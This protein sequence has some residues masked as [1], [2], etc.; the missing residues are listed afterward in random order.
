MDG[1][2]DPV[3]GAAVQRHGVALVAATLVR[4]LIAGGLMAAPVATAQ[5]AVAIVIES[6]TIEPLDIAACQYRW[7]VTV[8]NDGDVPAGRE[9][10]MQ[11]SQGRSRGNWQ[12]AGGIAV[13][14]IAPGGT[15]T[16]TLTFVRAADTNQIRIQL[17][18]EGHV[19]AEKIGPLPEQPPFD[20]RLTNFRRTATTY[21]VDVDNPQAEGVADVTLQV[22]RGSAKSPR[23]WRPGGGQ[24]LECVP[25][26]GHFRR[27][28]ELASDAPLL[29]VQLKRGSTVLRERV[30]DTRLR[31]QM[32]AGEAPAPR[33]PGA[34]STRVPA[35]RAESASRSQQRPRTHDVRAKIRKMQLRDGKN[36]VDRTQGGLRLYVRARGGQPLEYTIS[37]RGGR[38]LRSTR[39]SKNGVCLRCA[40]DDAG[41]RHCWQ[42]VCPSTGARQIRRH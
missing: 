18:R 35:R 9:I 8:R 32:G 36:L 33:T 12:P 31:A 14:S 30:F 3:C 34:R 27:S 11:A 23:E 42:V 20:L 5:G 41:Q 16:G 37:D 13:D 21:T 6:L 4:G 25:G 15:G 19:I 26:H 28:G 22:Y 17:W 38:P 2:L 10:T 7:R 1:E 29:K 40:R 39:S 24:S